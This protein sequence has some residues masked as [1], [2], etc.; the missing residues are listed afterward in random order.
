MKKKTIANLIMVAMIL[1]I[2]AAGILG[3]GHI[4][5]WFDKAD[6]EAALLTDFHGI[7][8]LEREG[9]AYPVEQ[10]TVL[11]TGD[12]IT[13]ELGATAVIQAGESALTLGEQAAVE[14]TDPTVSSFAATVT[15]GEVFV[16]AKN[17]VTLSFDGKEVGFAETVAAL[18]VRSG[19][20]SISVFAGTVE[21]AGAGQILDWVGETLRVAGLSIESL[22]EFCIHQIRLANESRTLCFS[23]EDLDKLEEARRIALQEEADRKLALEQEKTPAEEPN[24]EPE[25]EEQPEPEAPE[26]EEPG[27][28]EPAEPK[29][30]QTEEPPAEAPAEEKPGASAPEETAPSEPGEAE[31]APEPEPEPEPALTV[32]LSIYCDTILNNWDNLD[33]AK[34]GYVPA[35]GVILTATVE[36]TAGETVFDV[37]KRACSAFGIQLEYSWTP[38]YNSYYIEGINN[39]Y[40]FDCGPESGWMYKVDGWFPNYGCSGYTL[41]GG[42]NIVWCYTCNGLGADVGGPAW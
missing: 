28:S 3:V 26:T 16:N 15:A 1:A 18:S 40:E 21:D 11:R 10:D 6:A 27:Q 17:T 31:P 5:G 9:V 20:Q 34:A 13:C 41:S 25:S 4:R 7:V 8:N 36:I 12:R 33:P 39:L 23:N 24:G 30:S 14:I 32:S 2:A 42:E 35:N 38:M 19:A 37:L 22:N 29:E